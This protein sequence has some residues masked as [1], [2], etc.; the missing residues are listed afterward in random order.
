MNKATSATRQLNEKMFLALG[1]VLGASSDFESLLDSLIR[2][3]VQSVNPA[4]AGVIYL[5]NKKRQQLTA[6][7]SYGYPG[8][9]VKCSLLPKEGA[10]G[11]CYTLRKSIVFP[12]VEAVTEQEETMRPTSLDCY[13]KMR[14][15]LPPT[16]SMIAIPLKLQ[17]RIFGVI[18]LEH[19]RPQH[20]AFSGA[21]L[22]QIEALSNWISVIIDDM[23]S[24]LELKHSKRSYRE[25]LGRFITTSE[26]ERKKIAREIHD[27]VNQLLLSI[28]L[29]LEDVK[30]TL[31]PNMVR[32]QES[33]GII[34][35]NINQAFDDLHR[36]S[37]SL[38]PLALDELGLPQ[39]L[40]WYIHNL[41]KEASLSIKL[42]L[43]G[44]TD[45]R[46]APVI[47][48]ELF[49]IA[50]EALSNIVKHAQA[51]SATV[52]LIF[53]R[54]QIVLLVEDNGKGFDTDIVSTMSYGI[55]NL[56]IWGMRERAEICGGTLEID[57]ATNCGTSVK[58]EIP[59][60]SYDWGAY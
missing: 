18:T 2:Q 9:N 5:Y 53:N 40:D 27:E 36:L 22:L 12:S 47:E 55:N 13:T 7:A 37:L 23:Q 57:S 34:M 31:P 33:L 15:G 58:I 3:L 24:H 16:I 32:E 25:L 59:I 4:D 45:R 43:K 50:Q 1:N 41:K 35:T 39:A 6:E 49:R 17:K 14:E 8:G 56:G 46:P 48:T 42:S 54:L 20:G 19:Y 28:R 30:N 60:R 10:P 11:Q 29:N 44:L 52:T 21:D 26:E 38:R 51:T